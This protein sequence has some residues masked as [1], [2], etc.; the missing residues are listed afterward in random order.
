MKPSDVLGVPDVARLP[1]VQELC[2]IREPGRFG[3][4][5]DALF[6]RAMREISAWHIERSDLTARELE[7]TSPAWVHRVPTD[8]RPVA[9]IATEIITLTPGPR[10][11]PITDRGRARERRRRSPRCC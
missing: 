4:A 10:I 2:E 5:S 3:A 1:T 8:G 9:A 11:R 7:Q 6:V